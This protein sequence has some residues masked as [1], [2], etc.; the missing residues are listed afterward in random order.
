MFVSI[1][2]ARRGLAE[3]GASHIYRE[4]LE[5]FVREYPDEREVAFAR[6][7]GRVNVIGEHTDYNG[8]PVMPMAID[9]EIVIALARQ[10][11]PDI[12]LASVNPAFPRVEVALSGAIEPYQTGHWGNYIKAA[13]QAVWEWAK[14]HSPDA[15]PLSGI[16]GVVG[17]SIP[18]G[19]GLSSSSAL[20]VAVG[21]ALS[22]DLP[23]SKRELADL[24][25]YG[26]RYVGTQGGGM[27]QA[28][29]LLGEAGFALHIGFFPLTVRPVKLP[30]GHVLV[31][32]N[33][34]VVAEKTGGARVVYNTRVAEC[35]L[36]LE[37]LKYGAREAVPSVSGAS[38]L[39]HFLENVPDWEHYV[40]M[41]P[42][43]P[44]TVAQVAARIG[45][46]E[47]DLARRCL[48]QRDGSLLQPPQHGFQPKKR[49]R[50]VLSEGARV[51]LAAAVA[52]EGDAAELGRMMDA[53]HVSCADDYEVSC[54][55]LDALV[56]AMRDGGALGARLTGAGFG[57]CAVALVRESDA[58]RVMDAIWRDYYESYLPT[59]GISVPADRDSVL[60][61]CIPSAGAGMVGF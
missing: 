12:E 26:E 58:S 20:V 22:R 17:G 60:F 36:G 32:A 42:N 18:P 55:E 31:V 38:L 59:R 3:A 41:L 47:D 61:A 50:H 16:R 29:S 24:L 45:D 46:T 4:V 15:L 33:S 14:E 21:C 19:S 56:K 2:Q 6:A 43:G 37:M 13:A 53:S 10:D 30:D 57:G 1:D 35:R 49:C 51:D 27:D 8:L 40:S 25:A 11:T 9:R 23:I 28:A 48:V 54:P 52:E 5:C 7:P 34:M 39:K 44:V